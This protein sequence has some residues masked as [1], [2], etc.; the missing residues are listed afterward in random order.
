MALNRFTAFDNEASHDLNPRQH[1][2]TL[3]KYRIIEQWDRDTQQNYDYARS[4]KIFLAWLTILD[5]CKEGL[6]L[7]GMNIS[8]K[9]GVDMRQVNNVCCL[10]KINN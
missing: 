6:P 10:R 4:A 1:R 8:S 5:R 9:E 3:M 7:H 2:F